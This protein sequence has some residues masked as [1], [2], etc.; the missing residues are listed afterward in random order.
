MFCIYQR[1]TPQLSQKRLEVSAKGQRWRT[2]LGSFGFTPMSAKG[3]R[4]AIAPNPK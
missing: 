3:L 4:P 2:M 1:A